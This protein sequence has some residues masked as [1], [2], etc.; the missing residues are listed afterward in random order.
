MMILEN[1]EEEKYRIRLYLI[2]ETRDYLRQ[3]DEYKQKV[4]EIK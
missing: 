2:D 4:N 3:A 1:M